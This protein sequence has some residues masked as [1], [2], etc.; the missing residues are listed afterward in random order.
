MSTLAAVA[1]PV[2]AAPLAPPTAPPAPPV[3]AVSQAAQPVDSF[4]PSPVAKREAPLAP[5]SPEP[6]AVEPAKKP[7]LM[8][9]AWEA[10]KK[11]AKN[12]VVRQ[13]ATTVARRVLTGGAL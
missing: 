2:I 12:P 4:E 10:L 13:V 1:R 3:P 11:L 5:A 9:R 8:K 7:G 6:V